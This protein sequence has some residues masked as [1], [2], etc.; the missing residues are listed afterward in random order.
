MGAVVRVTEE[1][2]LSVS[3]GVGPS[4]SSSLFLR[5]FTNQAGGSGGTV[6]SVVPSAS[7]PSPII[8][9]IILVPTLIP[10]NWP[11]SSY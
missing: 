10:F 4:Q 5:S 1:G 6:G 8:L 7:S 3:L 2:N 11:L 9:F